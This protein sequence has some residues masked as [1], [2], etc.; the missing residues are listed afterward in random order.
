MYGPVSGE[1]EFAL[2]EL[3][4]ETAILKNREIYVNELRIVRSYHEP[5]KDQIVR[6]KAV[7]FG[8]PSAVM[9]QEVLGAVDQPDLAARLQ[10]SS[11]GRA[12]VVRGAFQFPKRR[13]ANS[14]VPTKVSTNV[15]RTGTDFRTV[16]CQLG[17]ASLVPS[18]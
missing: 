12:V 15:T 1:N 8:A 7:V 2:S 16:F 4:T 17:E 6:Y 10:L 11:R 3:Q 9:P 13:A 14:M 18:S 5:T